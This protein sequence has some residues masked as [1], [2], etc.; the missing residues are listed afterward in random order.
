M[1]SIDIVRAYNLR[2]KVAGIVV[3]KVRPTSSE[4]RY[5]LAELALAYGADLLQP[6]LPD[7][8]VLQQAAGA[9]T[10]VQQW[11]TQSGREVSRIL[12][13]YLDH[14]LDTQLDTGPL[15]ASG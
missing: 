14:L 7:R 13:S 11:R 12:D 5:R 2:L 8:A 1:E 15:R 4:H 10:P 9:C 3:N 6:P